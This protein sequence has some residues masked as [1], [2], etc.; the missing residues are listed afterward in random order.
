MPPPS[1]PRYI[2]TK[3]EDGGMGEEKFICEPEEVPPPQQSAL[4]VRPYN[5]S[6][7]Y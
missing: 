4:Y 2:C 7:F 1:Q 3:K 6:W 5:R